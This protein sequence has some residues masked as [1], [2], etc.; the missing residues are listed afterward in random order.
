MSKGVVEVEVKGV[1]PTTGGCAVFLGNKEKVFVIHVDQMVGVA[2]TMFMRKAPK[3]RPQTH[4]LM[5]DILLAVGANVQRVVINHFDEGVYFA[6]LII[7]CE[8]ELHEKKIIEIDARPSDS[9]A[10]ATQQD[11]PIYVSQD[12]WDSA[13]DESELLKNMEDGGFPTG[14]EEGI[15]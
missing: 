6:R 7:S 15:V 1:L 2:I 5:A 3:V 12:V 9:I 13:D 11:A 10:L 14:P 8:N 4:D